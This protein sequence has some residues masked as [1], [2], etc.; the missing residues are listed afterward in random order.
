VDDQQVLKS[1][2][3]GSKP[4]F[5]LSRGKAYHPTH[6]FTHYLP[7]IPAPILE[8]TTSLFSPDIKTLRTPFLFLT[9]DLPPPPL[10]QS[11]LQ[12]DIIPQIPL[13]TLLSKYSG[14][15]TQELLTPKEDG[16]SEVTLRRFK[17]EE[18]PEFVVLNVKRFE[19][20]RFGEEKNPTIVNFPLRGVDF[21]DCKHFIFPYLP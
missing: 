13:T 4:V 3:Y 15:T 1:G 2:E 18:L 14:S 9:L 5:D 6:L 7:S 17:I 11:H 20:N 21:R 8:L 12:N 16:R 19:R 10:F